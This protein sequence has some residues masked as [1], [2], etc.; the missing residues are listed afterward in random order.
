MASKRTDIFFSAFDAWISGREGNLWDAVTRSELLFHPS[1]IRHMLW[2]LR[3]NMTL[4]ALRS[5]QLDEYETTDA[6]VLCLHAGNLP[7]VGFQDVVAVY[8]SG[9]PYRGKISRKDPFLLPSFLE[10][11][12]SRDP[13]FNAKW[14]VELHDLNDDIHTLVFAG[15][16]SSIPAVRTLLQKSG[17]L[18]RDTEEIVRTAS[19]SIAYLPQPEGKDFEDLAEAV[20]RYDGN[21]CR[22]VKMVVSDSEL[23]DVACGL[24]D[25]F[26]A[27]W[28]KN[29]IHPPKMSEL[30]RYDRATAAAV[31]HPSLQIE[32]LL[33]VDS[34]EPGG[35]AHRLLW[36]KGGLAMLESLITTHKKS[37]QQ[38]YSR[39]GGF[40]SEM[41]P[42][43]EPLFRAQDP[44]I[45][46]MPDGIDLLGRLV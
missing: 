21:G 40:L 19:M 36:L 9:R 35:N 31:G 5:W 7:L 41:I 14:S 20:L 27:W 24:E 26:E 18:H 33:W 32:H 12:C 4:N 37:V 45:C 22:S 34:P 10:V 30:T 38:V 25:A 28:I 23:S 15:S 8:L 3:E 6:A 13:L 43:A 29:G 1:D 2:S 39:N 44:P 11:L 17:V 42:D 16:E 46:W